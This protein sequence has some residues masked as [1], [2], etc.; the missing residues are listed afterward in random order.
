MSVDRF[1]NA[2]K[3]HTATQMETIGRA[4]MAIIAT[5]S[6]AIGKVR[7]LLQPSGVQTGFAPLATPWAGNGWGFYAPPIGGEQ[8]VMLPQ[9]GDGENL[10][11]A[12]PIWSQARVPPPANPG[13]CWLVHQSGAAIKLLNTG[14]V[15]VSDPSGAILELANNGTVNVTGDLQVSGNIYDVAGAHGH[16]DH[17]RTYYNL[18]KHGGPSSDHL[19]V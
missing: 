12:F 7:A 11:A 1:I 16:V 3:P 13:E 17:F 6:A 9:E 10:I 19:V 15:V 2:I 18:H 14:H 5:V 4:R 8:F